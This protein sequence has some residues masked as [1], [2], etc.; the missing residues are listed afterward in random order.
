MKRFVS[1][2]VILACALVVVGYVSFV[3]EIQRVKMDALSTLE[4]RAGLFRQYIRLISAS[5]T[6]MKQSFLQAYQ[7]ASGNELKM[8]VLDS[9]RLFPEHKVYGLSPYDQPDTAGALNG[10]LTLRPELDLANPELRREL[11]ATLTLDAQM[12]TLMQEVEMTIWV[13]Y[14]S[15]QGFLYLVPK[16]PVADFQFTSDLYQRA[17]WAQATPEQ[18]P[19]GGQIISDL[20]ADAGGKGLMISVSDPIYIDGQFLGVV[21]LDVGLELM[22]GLLR[23]GEATGHSCLLDE[24]QQ[25]VACSRPVLEHAPSLPTVRLDGRW[26]KVGRSWYFQVP[27]RDGEL[28][29][30]HRLGEGELYRSAI[31]SSLTVWGLLVLG[32]LLTYLTFSLHRS[33]LRNKELMQI[34][35][36]TLLYNRRGFH[37]LLQPIY[38]QAARLGQSCGVLLIDIDFFKRVNDSHGHAVGDEVLLGLAKELQ[39]INREGSLVCR[40]GGEEFLVLLQDCDLHGAQLV[41]QRIHQVVR[42]QS[43]SRAALTITV[44]IGA[45][46]SSAS[47]PFDVLLQAADDA[48]YQAKQNGRN[49]TVACD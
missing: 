49:Q 7:R 30:E 17:F 35:P 9:I 13:Y 2:P 44:S 43:F 33:A 21:S 34:D 39:S 18:N 42:A 48:L 15:A 11:Q 47:E 37:A 6:A 41:A 27:V 31:M 1:L 4:V 38:A 22:E 25:R 19:H 8:A 14:T 16:L 45:C 46:A 23:V 29:L 36:L 32:A 40:W 3:G 28:Y 5:N 10:T 24:R 12:D 20:Y 26:H